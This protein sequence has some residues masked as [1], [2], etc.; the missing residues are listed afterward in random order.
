MIQELIHYLNYIKHTWITI[1]GGDHNLAGIIDGNTVDILEARAPATSSADKEYIQEQF[2][3]NSIFPDVS[4]EV[5]RARLQQNVLSIGGT[6]PSIRTFTED[7]LWLED[8]RAAVKTLIDPGKLQ[9]RDAL[10]HAWHG[11]ERNSVVLE[12]ADGLTKKASVI[13]DEESQ[14]EVA[15]T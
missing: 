1:I 15:C 11:F 4:D 7:T 6:I 3:N 2:E 10:R 9:L 5:T 13:I 12:Y 8:S 14:F